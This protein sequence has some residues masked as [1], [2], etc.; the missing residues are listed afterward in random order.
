M[1]ALRNKNAGKTLVDWDLNIFIPES[2]NEET[3]EYY[4]DPSAWVIHVYR[5][6]GNTHIE[7]D[8]PLALTAGE[9]QS[10][11]LNGDEYFKD[12]TD[13][14]YGLVGFREKYWHKMSDRL[15][16]YFD[17]LPKYEEDLQLNNN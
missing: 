7:H 16:L 12:E 15:K 6:M 3:E 5:F 2:Y 14:W 9:I 8:K 11:M 10:L 4:F 17:S 13:V 1:I